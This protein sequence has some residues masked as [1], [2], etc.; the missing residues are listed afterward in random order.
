MT[1]QGKLDHIV[2]FWG[3]CCSSW[4]HINSGTSHRNYFTPMGQ[5]AYQSVQTANLLTARQQSQ[6]VQTFRLWLVAHAPPHPLH[7]LLFL[8]ATTREVN[9]A[10]LGLRGYGRSSCH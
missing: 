6:D 1:L 8:P 5:E 3:I 4:V 9:V 10:H 7:S 2:T